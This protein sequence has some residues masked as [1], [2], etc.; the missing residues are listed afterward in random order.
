MLFV[1]IFHHEDLQKNIFMP[2]IY[3]SINYLMII[4]YRVKHFLSILNKFL[5][6]INIV[7]KKKN[8]IFKTLRIVYKGFG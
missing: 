4:L 3:L 5:R 8:R 2:L 7:Y 1:T 6:P